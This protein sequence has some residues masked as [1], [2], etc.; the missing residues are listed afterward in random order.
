MTYYLANNGKLLIVD[1]TGV[2]EGHEHKG[3]GKEIFYELMRI[4][5]EQ[6]KKVILLCPFVKTMFEKD[7][8]T[9]DVLK[10]QLAQNCN[11]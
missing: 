5:R 10:H 3:V 1:H 2:N 7:K 6:E 11:V 4:L 9:Q 8:D